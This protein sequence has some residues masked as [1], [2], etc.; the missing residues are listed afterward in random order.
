MKFAPE[1]GRPHETLNSSV[2]SASGKFQPTIGQA[3]T[4]SL[5]TMLSL[6]STTDR[7]SCSALGIHRHAKC[8]EKILQSRKLL[9]RH[10]L[11][12]L[13]LK[14]RGSDALSGSGPGAVSALLFKLTDDGYA[15]VWCRHE[16]T[17]TS[18]PVVNR[19]CFADCRLIRAPMTSVLKHQHSR[20]ATPKAVATRTAVVCA[21]CSRAAA[22]FSVPSNRDSRAGCYL[23]SCRQSV[24][25]VPAK[26]AFSG[27]RLV[28]RTCSVVGKRLWLLS[29]EASPSSP[30]L[31]IGASCLATTSR[32]R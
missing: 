15:I 12:G 25:D 27:T 30:R 29:L 3:Q 8:P 2:Q 7:N 28:S 13:N 4:I 18:H 32:M 5:V 9:L 19:E 14:D 10:A 23:H 24:N 16:T 31:I 20:K 1:L 11:T 17:I 26:H 6:G 22:F 21:Q